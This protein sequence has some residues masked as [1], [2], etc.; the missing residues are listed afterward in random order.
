MFVNIEEN[1]LDKNTRNKRFT[2]G[3]ERRIGEHRGSYHFSRQQFS[4]VL[5]FHESIL[6][7][8]Y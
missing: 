3:K 5:I 1:I 6:L 4:S 7:P 8:W 2:S